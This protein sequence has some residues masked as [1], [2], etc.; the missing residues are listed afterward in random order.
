[1]RQF[2]ISAVL[3]LSAMT[4]QAQLMTSTTVN[5]LYEESIKE[6]SNDFYYNAE[7]DSNGNITTM[8]VYKKN[9][10]VDMLRPVCRYRYDYADDGMLRC[11]TMY[12]WKR[13][14]WRCS[15]RHDYTLTAGHYN[16]EYS[17]WNRKA[18][19]FDKATEKM[20]YTLLSNDSV[21]HV[22]YYKRKHTDQPFLLSWQV[23]VEGQ[24]FRMEDFLTQ[25]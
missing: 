17:R 1:M 18:S 8:Y 24:S 7:R 13:G 10:D 11:R 9:S 5:K 12:V 25:K 22:S 2:I 20:T 4:A 3:F 16:V 14:Q 19:D 15:G 6:N 21:N 23:S